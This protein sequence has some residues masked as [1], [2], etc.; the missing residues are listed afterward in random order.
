[1]L[2][3]LVTYLHPNLANATGELSKANNSAN[4][5]AHKEFPCIIKYVLEMKN[6]GLKIKPTQNSN[7]PWEIICFSDSNYA[8]DI[9][10]R[11]SING[12]IQYV[13]GVPFSWWSKYQ[14]S[15]SLSRSETEYIALS[16]AVKEVMFVIH[17]LG[18]M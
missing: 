13:L 15:V 17:L 18:S 1:M 14:K 10:S 6:L 5:A 16:E 8:G 3:Y 11:Q 7:E 9:V 2:L 12:F 4:P